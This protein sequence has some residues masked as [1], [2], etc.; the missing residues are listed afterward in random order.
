LSAG[1]KATVRF[2]SWQNLR[3]HYEKTNRVRFG[4]V[5]GEGRKKHVAKF[6]KLSAPLVAQG[7]AIVMVK[8]EL[9]E[10]VAED[11]IASS[12][13]EIRQTVLRS[14]STILA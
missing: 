10:V 13:E 5:I 14:L 3:F 4:L 9:P 1:N 2:F 7:V 12:I 8:S 11:A 6:T